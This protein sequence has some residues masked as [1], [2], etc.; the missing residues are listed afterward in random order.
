MGWGWGTLYAD[1]TDAECATYPMTGL[2]AYQRRDTISRSLATGYNVTTLV[3]AAVS[4]VNIS[5]LISF[6]FVM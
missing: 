3:C 1:A 5:T 6:Y 2:P 4:A